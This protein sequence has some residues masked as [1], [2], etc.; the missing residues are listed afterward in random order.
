MSQQANFVAYDGASTPIAHSLLA[1]GTSREA[2][3]QIA[4]WEERIAGVPFE[5]QVRVTTRKRLLKNGLEHVS[6]TVKVPY[7]ETAVGA[8]AAGYTAAP[9]VANE[10]TIVINGYFAKRTTAANRRLIRQLAVNIFN[11]VLTTQTPVTT[12]PA[13]ELFDLSMQAS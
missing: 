7:Q 8:N 3:V 9:A 4:D 6:L 10:D 11:G 2:G 12:G 5:A 13:A 1:M